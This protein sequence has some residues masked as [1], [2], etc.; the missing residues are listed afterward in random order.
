MT[1][2]ISWSQLRVHESCKQRGYLQRTGKKTII[3]NT[4]VFFPGTVTDRVVRDWLSGSPEDNLG[5]MPG[6]VEEIL[7]REYQQ[8]KDDGQ[9]MAWKN[10]SDRLQVLADCT[11][12]VTKI[13]P[14]L[15]KFVLPFEY[16]VDMRFSTP[17]RIPHP[18]KGSEEIL[19]IGAMDILVRDAVKRWML[20]DVK[21]TRDGSYWRKTEGQLTFYDLAVE[22]MFGSPTLRVGLLQPL[23]TQRVKPFEITEDK[24]SQMLQ[25]IVGMAHDIWNDVRTPRTDTSECGWCPTKH[26]CSRFEPVMVGTS[27]RME[28]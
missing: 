25:R 13:E 20:W 27:R 6:M 15:V 26:A 1:L 21:H 17:L 11:E 3:E 2:R 10:K 16:Q 14:D 18:R 7:E 4:R 19:L 23:C 9:V 12:A 24:R 22:L 8:I 5:A 28:F